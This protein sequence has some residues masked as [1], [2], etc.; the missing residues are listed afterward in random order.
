MQSYKL[1]QGDITAKLFYFY[2]I[3]III[4]F[5]GSIVIVLQKTELKISLNI[6]DILLIVFWL[7]NLIRLIFTPFTPLLND[8][9]ITFTILIGLY[10]A[11]KEA[12]KDFNPNKFSSGYILVTGFLISGFYQSTV[13][14]FQLNNIFGFYSNGFYNISGTFDNPGPF[15]GFIITVI[16]FAFGL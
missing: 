5:M 13:G 8:R 9:F 14:L 2:L 1:A 15:S 12:L 7:Y 3:S 6:L 4:T 10:I 16:P 11:W